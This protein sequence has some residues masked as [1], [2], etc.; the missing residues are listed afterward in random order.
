MKFTPIALLALAALPAIAQVEGVRP[1]GFPQYPALSPDGSTIVFSYAGDLWVVGSNGGTARRITTHPSDDL[2]SAFS[3]D[4]KTLAFESERE[5]ARAIFAMPVSKDAGGLVFGDVRRVTRADRAQTLSSF[6]ADGSHVYLASNHEPAMTRGTRLYQAKAD[7]SGPLARLTDAWGGT[8]TPTPDG[9]GITFTRNRF[10]PNR[11]RY[12]G[13]ATADIFRLDF[14]TG[15]FTQLTSNTAND[16]DGRILADGSLA[17]VSARDGQNNIWRLPKSTAEAAATQLTFFKP[18]PGEATISHG[19]RDFSATNTTGV[20]VVWDRLYT[21]DLAAQRPQPKALDVNLGGD[22]SQVDYQRMN[23]SKQVNEAALSPDGKTIALIARGEIFVRSTEKDRPTRRV[24]TTHARERDLAWSPDGKTLYYTSDESGVYGLYAATVDLAKE[25]LAP[26]KPDEEKPAEEAPAP[27]AKTDPTPADDKPDDKADEKADK[28]KE[29]PKIDHAKRWAESLTFKTAPVLVETANIRRPRPSPDGKHLLLTRGLGDLVLLDPATNA[30]RTILS[31]WDEP[32]ASWCSD[33]R[34]LLYARSDNDFNSD[35]WILDALTDNAA[36]VNIT[37]HPDND[38]SPR[39]SA[40]GKVLYFLSDRDAATNDEY[41]VYTVF[42]DAKLEAMSAYELADYFKEAAEAAKKRKPLGA[43]EKSDKKDKK[44]DKPD[45]K[46]EEKP[47][48]PQDEAKANEKADIKSDDAKPEEPKAPEPLKFDSADAYL[49]VREL[50]SLPGG[51]GDLATTPGGERVIFSASIDGSAALFSVD[52]KGKER[53]SIVSSSASNV[54]LNLTGEKVIYVAAGE[55]SIAKPA[56]GENDKMPIDAPVVIEVAQQQKQK[57]LEAARILGEQFYHPTLKGLD[58]PALTNRY[59]ALAMQTRTDAEFNS[60]GNALFGE[61]D[62]SHL[63]IRGGRD[64]AGEQTP[65]GYL[66]VDAAPTA[67]GWKITRVFAQGPASREAMRLSPGDTITHINGQA[68]AANG[69]PTA[70]LPVLLAGTSGRDTLLNAKNATGEERR[71]LITPIASGADS[72]LRYQDEVAR[73][74]ALVDKLSGGKLGY[75]HIRSMDL[76]SV[77]DYER[78]LY[79]AAHGKDGLLIDVRD[80]GGGWTADILLASLTAPR[81][82]YTVPRGADGSTMPRD[83]YPRDRRLIY[84]YNRPISVLINQNSYSNAEIFPHAIKTIG[85]G[86]LVG[87]QTFGAVISTGSASLIDGTTV[88][89]PFRGWHLLDGTDMENNGAKPDIAVAMTPEAET[90]GDDPQIETAVKEL[91]E[92]AA[93]EPFWD[94][95]R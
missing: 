8:P 89:T 10:D 67:D 12:V 24:T 39:L 38:V 93:R 90:K 76:P 37:R 92:R 86:K 61:L 73:R 94:I 55:A 88:R 54:T 87:V 23:L 29:E 4:G 52:Y 45:A 14:A 57:F 13:P 31:G 81:H 85:R 46:A 32:D 84:H 78:D 5:G 53:K 30:Q 58:W 71:F 17:F 59:L 82:A 50:V 16:A 77:R 36:S 47:D 91:L 74:T 18:A 49:R 35:I 3:P 64:T 22:F 1:V 41:S 25:D 43:E 34:H 42:L 80:N 21:I 20:F 70:D 19:V 65:L 68:V 27:D 33:S 9:S 72:N 56:G 63:G 40:D 79:A 2:R 62:G 44:A 7:G 26:K 60:V 75:L 48:A 6:S 66:G 28:K 69:A 83:A 95:K 51:M 15:A 11:P